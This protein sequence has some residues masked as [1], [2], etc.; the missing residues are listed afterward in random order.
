MIN[1]T[2]CKEISYYFLGELP[3]L[4]KNYHPSSY[5]RI[6]VYSSGESWVMMSQSH[7]DPLSLSCPFLYVLNC[8]PL[9]FEFQGKICIR[10]S[11]FNYM[12][13]PFN[14]AQAG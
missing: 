13:A 14:F 4:K 8:F 9:Y 5:H 2:N 12:I 11:F 6:L 3:L 1:L 10:L 7:V